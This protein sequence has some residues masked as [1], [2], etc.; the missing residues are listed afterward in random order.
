MSQSLDEDLSPEHQYLCKKSGVAKGNEFC[1]WK[2]GLEMW[3][4]DLLATTLAGK[5]Q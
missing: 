3:G 5:L 2:K 1:H 4:W